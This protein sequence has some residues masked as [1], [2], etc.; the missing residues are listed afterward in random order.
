MWTSVHCLVDKGGV[1]WEEIQSNDS[2]SLSSFLLSFFRSFCS[3]RFLA[4]L[5]QMF[6]SK[7]HSRGG[8]IPPLDGRGGADKAT[9]NAGYCPVCKCRARPSFPSPL[10]C[11]SCVHILSSR[12]NPVP[13]RP[14][15]SSPLVLQWL[16]SMGMAK[17]L[18]DIHMFPS[19]QLP[20]PHIRHTLTSTEMTV[21]RFSWKV[22]EK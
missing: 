6:R 12:P 8:D 22:S 2:F 17:V 19:Q 20:E 18:T 3:F 15:R 11:Q 1:L 5:L 10:F 4:G 16:S 14:R 9:R 13:K 7:A 21:R